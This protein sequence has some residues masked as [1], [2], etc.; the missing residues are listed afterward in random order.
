[1]STWTAPES[2]PESRKEGAFLYTNPLIMGYW[3]DL[4]AQFECEPEK[5]LL[6]AVVEDAVAIIHKGRCEH[7][8]KQN[9]LYRETV[10]WFRG[11]PDQ[12]TPFSFKNACLYLDLEPGYILRGLGIKC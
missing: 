4:R 2:Q 12:D 7:D 3:D 6:I 8:T 9:L 10:R 11:I 5:M 1:M